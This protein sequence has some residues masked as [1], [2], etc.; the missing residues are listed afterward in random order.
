MDSNDKGKAV[1]YPTLPQNRTDPNATLLE[2]EPK[3]KPDA[4]NPSAALEQGHEYM[5]QMQSDPNASPQKKLNPASSSKSTTKAESII[6]PEVRQKVVDEI[7]YGE[8]TD[9]ERILG[10]SRA[11]TQEEKYKAY[12]Y[13][14]KCV[15]PDHHQ[16]TNQSKSQAKSAFNLVNTA[17]NKLKDPNAPP[18]DEIEIGAS[19]APGAYD[20]GD[21]NSDDESNSHEG[22][23]EEKKEN[24]TT[25]QQKEK[26]I[27]KML[28][29]MNEL[30]INSRA[31]TAPSG[32]LQLYNAASEDVEKL[33]QNPNDEETLE[34]LKEAQQSILDQDS[35]FL[36]N[37]GQMRGLA[38]D[39]KSR[40]MQLRTNPGDIY[41][42]TSYAH[43]FCTF[44]H[45]KQY[46][47]WPSTWYL[48]RDPEAAHI[49]YCALANPH[50]EA[51]KKD[52]SSLDPETR[53]RQIEEWIDSW[54]QEAGVMSVDMLNVSALRKYYYR[55]AAAVPGSG[56]YDKHHRD[57]GDYITKHNF[58]I[59]WATNPPTS[60]NE[61]DGRGSAS[62]PVRTTGPNAGPAKN[63][64]PLS[65]VDKR[66]GG[67][68]TTRDG[69][70]IYGHKHWVIGK[71][72]AYLFAV[73][74]NRDVPI[75][76]LR[77]GTLVGH[78]SKKAYL[79]SNAVNKLK[80]KGE[81]NPDRFQSRFQEAV[82]VFVHTSEPERR[83]PE[84]WVMALM[85]D[86]SGKKLQNIE[87]ALY[88][89][90]E[91]TSLRR[92]IDGGFDIAKIFADHGRIPPGRLRWVLPSIDGK[93][94]KPSLGPPR[95]AENAQAQGTDMAEFEELIA[96]LRRSTAGQAPSLQP[97]PPVPPMSAAPS[98]NAVPFMNAAASTKTMPFMNAA[99][100]TNAVPSTSPE[101]SANAMMEMLMNQQ[102]QIK[103]LTYLVSQMAKPSTE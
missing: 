41:E 89:R 5:E 90:S 12:R 74:P 75:G 88:T 61:K 54:C 36:L 78:D 31:R 96:K 59:S 22:G 44:Q 2:L 67:P 11:A 94:N 62:D 29:R 103:H 60:V 27:Q 32:I 101:T 26:N 98:T 3:E 82:A 37:V 52:P 95:I 73:L 72:D 30:I 81:E 6:T 39:I 17:Y 86:S 92:G 77:S 100:S 71:N 69:A 83:S 102:S 64:S 85:A 28:D 24:L 50:V 47:N 45:E 23:Y 53:L 76:E 97:N 40:R 49:V 63:H 34:K 84:T 4:I 99:P 56:D 9:Y 51:L 48:D 43:S 16:Q 46:N 21:D 18:P 8:H 10:V 57:L 93:V 35:S 38:M 80:S 42:M 14:V 79:F 15:H 33:L 55:L 65:W 7:L 58:P 91:F 20:I 13:R 66:D 1:S 25:E 70:I 68:P 87:Y 19:W